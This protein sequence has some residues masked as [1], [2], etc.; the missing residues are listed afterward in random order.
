MMENHSFDNIFGKYPYSSNISSKSL[1]LTVPNDLLGLHSLPS[2]LSPVASGSFATPDPNEGY[3]PYHTDWNGGLMNNFVNGSG[4]Q[5]LPSVS[6]LLSL[7]RILKEQDVLAV[8]IIAG[9]AILTC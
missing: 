5:S 2:G 6:T 7:I 9:H 8:M 3:G 4:Q 1:N